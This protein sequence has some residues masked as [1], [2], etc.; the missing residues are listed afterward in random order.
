[1]TTFDDPTAVA[2]AIGSLEQPLLLVFDCDGVLSP[3]T[4]HADDSV[5]VDGIRAALDDLSHTDQVDVAVLSGRSLAGLEQFDFPDTIAMAGSYGGERKGRD[6]AELSDAEAEMLSKA[7]DLVG[8]A[9]ALAGDG[10]WVEHKPTSVVLHVREATTESGDAALA[11][12]ADASGALGLPAAHEGSRAFEL[13]ARSADKG[14]GIDLL[15]HEFDPASVVYFGDDVPDEDAFAKLRGPDI[16]VKVGPA[17]TLAT[18]RL[19]DPT[20]VLSTVQA[21][22]ARLR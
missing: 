20:A 10:A 5:L 1:M 11:F 21:L 19:E 17:P 14:T 6:L 13:M 4:D 2:A 7:T 8:Q 22:A 9:A 12:L 16:G 18:R 3:I 15:R